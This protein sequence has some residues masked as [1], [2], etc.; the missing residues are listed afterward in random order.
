MLGIAYTLVYLNQDFIN[1][2][3]M[4][5]QRMCVV[6]RWKIISTKNKV[7]QKQIINAANNINGKTIFECMLTDLT[8]VLSK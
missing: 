8:T 1:L 7:V 3:K 6:V 4:K 2:K 5:Y